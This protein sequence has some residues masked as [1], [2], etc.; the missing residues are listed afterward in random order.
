MDHQARVIFQSVEVAFHNLQEKWHQIAYFKKGKQ[1]P[2]ED[3]LKLTVFRH[4]QGISNEEDKLLTTPS[5]VEVSITHEP[6]DV[7]LLE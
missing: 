6:T 1:A 7:S 4:Q 2:L 5:T 3:F